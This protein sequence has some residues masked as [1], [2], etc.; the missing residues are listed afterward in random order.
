MRRFRWWLARLIVGKKDWQHTFRLWVESGYDL[1]QR[2]QKLPW[3]EEI[4]RG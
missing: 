1:V 3:H 4:K 2:A